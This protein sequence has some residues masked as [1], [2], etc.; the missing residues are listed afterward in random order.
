MKFD[1]DFFWG[2]LFAPINK[3]FAPDPR[4]VLSI[5]FILFLLFCWK[6]KFFTHPMVV[7]VPAVVGGII[8]FVG[9]VNPDFQLI[10]FKADNVPIVILLVVVPFSRGGRSAKPC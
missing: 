6:I 9:L 8:F 1:N 10:M 7:A 4:Y 3:I 2:W 5:A